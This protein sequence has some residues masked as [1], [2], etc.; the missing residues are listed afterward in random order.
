MDSQK[1]HQLT[2]KI[3]RATANDNRTS[4]GFWLRHLIP[5]FVIIGVGGALLFWRYFPSG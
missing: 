1:D 4:I 2:W 3:I 5:W